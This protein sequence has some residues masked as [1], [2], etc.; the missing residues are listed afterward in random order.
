MEEKVKE[1]LENK[2]KELS[3]LKEY[4][5]NQMVNID[6]FG[7]SKRDIVMTNNNRI[8]KINRK[9]NKYLQFSF[10]LYNYYRTIIV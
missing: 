8:K 7:W 5:L 1:L 4:E 6:K 2:I 10:L 3:Q 9:N